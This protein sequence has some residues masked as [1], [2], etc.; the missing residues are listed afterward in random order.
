[1]EIWQKSACHVL[2]NDILG[3]AGAF[4]NRALSVQPQQCVS[5]YHLKLVKNSDDK[6]FAQKRPTASHQNGMRCYQQNSSIDF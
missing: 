5:K 3:N 2:C 4:F 1:M 6:E